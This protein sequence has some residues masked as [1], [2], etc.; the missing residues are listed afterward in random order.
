MKYS[1]EFIAYNRMVHEVSGAVLEGKEIEKRAPL[2]E[3]PLGWLP[4]GW[5]SYSNNGS[6]RVKP[7]PVVVNGVDVPSPE[8]TLPAEGV[9][10]YT[11]DAKESDG[12]NT[13][14]SGDLENYDLRLLRRGLIHLTKENALKHAEALGFTK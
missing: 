9:Q 13:I 1:E 7:R 5:G 2:G 8:V 10:Y 11:P 3:E 4:L 6:Y 12:V 14:F